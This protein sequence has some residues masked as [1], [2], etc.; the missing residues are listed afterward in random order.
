[1][2]T[3][4]KVLAA[5]KDYLK[6]DDRYTILMTPRG[7]TI[8]EWDTAQQNWAGAE[9]CATPEQ[10]RGLL[11]EDLAGYLEYKITLCDRALTHGERQMIQQQAAKIADSL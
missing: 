7:Y 5:F 4:E 10:M 9:F 3:F 1:M 6:E 2:L 11:L 8:M